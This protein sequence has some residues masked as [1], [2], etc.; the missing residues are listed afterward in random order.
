MRIAYIAPYQGKDLI[1]KRPCLYNLSLAERVKIQLIAEMLQ[2]G[3]HEVEILS[4]G[5]LEPL[6]GAAR[7]RPKFYGAFEESERF[8][9]R[10]PIYY[11]S[12][13]AVKFLTGIWESTQAQRLLA[14]R[15]AADPFD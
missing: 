1:Q 8:H 12:A 2:E 3:G 5:A 13:L 11:V 6:V 9:P 15:H 14:R 7:F 4:Q 10:I